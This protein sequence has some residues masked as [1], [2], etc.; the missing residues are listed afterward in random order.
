MVGERIKPEADHVLQAVGAAPE[1]HSL[2][3]AEYRIA[4]GFGRESLFAG[5]A[6]P[7]KKMLFRRIC[8]AKR[9]FA[10]DC[11]SYL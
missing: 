1:W 6:P 8:I 11:L 7:V 2:F 9:F 10:D 4:R 5:H 3:G